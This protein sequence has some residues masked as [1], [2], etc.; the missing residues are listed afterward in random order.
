MAWFDQTTNSTGS[1]CARLSDDAAKVRR[2]T[3]TNIITIIGKGIIITIVGIII[4]TIITTIIGTI[5]RYKEPLE[6]GS[7][8]SFKVSQDSS[9]PSSSESTTTGSSAW[10]PQLFSL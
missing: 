8:L 4:V 7:D 3:T 10:S 5:I 6:Q 1:L 2:I 9:S